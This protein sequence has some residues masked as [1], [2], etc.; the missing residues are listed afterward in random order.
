[1]VPSSPL[2][3]PLDGWQ[4][5][6]LVQ[7]SE[8]QLDPAL[9]KILPAE[10][11]SRNKLIPVARE[12]GVLQVASSAPISQETLDELRIL[13]DCEIALRRAHSHEIEKAVEDLYMGL[14]LD[15][16][17]QEDVEVLSEEDQ[18]IGDLQKMAK[19]ALVIKLVNM[20]FRQAIQ[21]RA[22]DIHIEPFEREVKVRYRVDG[23]L[24]EA[25]SLPKRLQA[26]VISRIKILAELNIAERRLPQDGRIRLKLSGREY[27]IRVS[28]VPTYFG[29]TAALRILDKTHMLLQ[30]DDLG[31]SSLILRDFE[32][33][34]L[35][36]NGIIL[37]TG[38]TGSGKTTTLYAT[39]QKV[40]SPEKNIITIE[41]PVEYQ[42]DGISQIAV[43]PKIQLT[44][45]NGLRSILR[46][47]P[48]IILVGEIR[49]RET[50][51]IAVQAS[52]TGHLVF[53]TL[54]TNDAAGAIARLRD[55]GVEPYLIASSLIGVLAQ[56]LVRL[57]CPHCREE[58]P[59]AGRS[60]SLL[61]PD[62]ASSRCSRGRGCQ[63]CK[64]SGY[65]GRQGIYEFLLMDDSIK[66]AVNE[67]E[68]AIAIRQRAILKGFRTLWEDGLEKAAAG[69]TTL[70]EVLRVA[71][72]EDSA[73]PSLE[74]D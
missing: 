72:T 14:L 5:V 54:H 55:M 61:R 62:L 21:D 33:L 26:A 25:Q 74:V 3:S 42:L 64:N 6:Q 70:E 43:R 23:I 37:V 16:I 13:S 19:E 8:V 48:D 15:D 7:L 69:R 32:S 66:E 58:D 30:L 47:D 40:Y 60:L 71:K 39:L 20:I 51:E 29:E 45:A 17:H 53:S 57:V 59:Q 28:I 41:D 34:I 38:P 50:A 31:L 2:R 68:S 18:E 67:R 52:L 63:H 24:N 49:D 12:D 10:F 1:M 36:P 22:S 73:P 11:A 35:R 27:D 9:A 46:Q 4:E 44:F 56:R 65:L